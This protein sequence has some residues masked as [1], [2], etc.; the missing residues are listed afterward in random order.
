MDR[1]SKLEDRLKRVERVLGLGK[2]DN[3]SRE[4]SR[5]PEK[6]RKRSRTPTNRAPFDSIDSIH[7]R[8]TDG[9]GFDPDYKKNLR[10]IF[11]AYGDIYHLKLSQDSKSCNI[12]YADQAMRD[13]ALRD[14]DY[15]KNEKKLTVDMFK[16]SSKR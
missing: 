8:C 5:S 16:P 9:L 11:S 6:R 7:V 14:A 13:K 12:R 15:L 2:D 4:R 10:D 1:L 3:N